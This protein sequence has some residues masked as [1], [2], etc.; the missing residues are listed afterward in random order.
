MP[1]PRAALLQAV[2]HLRQGDWQAA[3]A[4]VQKDERSPLACWLH[5]IVHLMEGDAANARY[6]YRLADRPF[7]AGADVAA[8]IA[9]ARKELRP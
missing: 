3:H 7:P 1:L 6:W 8:E 5:G 2:E 4:I 9:A